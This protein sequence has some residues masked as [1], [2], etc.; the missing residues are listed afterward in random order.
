[1]TGVATNLIF[2]GSALEEVLDGYDEDYPERGRYM[3]WYRELFHERTRHAKAG[4]W[5][6]VYEF[7]K[8]LDYLQ[9][10][11]S[12]GPGPLWRKFFAALI[13][14]EIDEDVASMSSVD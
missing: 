10:K 3:E 5:P 1:M 6:T 4:D 11:I 13:E 9:T 12:Y 8:N 2:D 7:E 14:E